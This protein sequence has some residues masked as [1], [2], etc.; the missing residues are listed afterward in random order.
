M[1]DRLDRL[2]KSAP[3]K[4]DLSREQILLKNKSNI[5]ELP[6]TAIHLPLVNMKAGI[7][8]IKTLAFTTTSGDVGAVLVLLLCLPY[9]LLLQ[10]KG[11]IPSMPPRKMKIQKHG[12]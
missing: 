1:S 11:E 3:L 5:G 12:I 7:T 9:Q 4:S 2:P 10:A 8:L 6:T